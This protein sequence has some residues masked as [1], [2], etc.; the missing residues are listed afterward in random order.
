VDMGNW[1]TS[2][3]YGGRICG[4][5]TPLMPIKNLLDVGDYLS[6]A[7]VSRLQKGSNVLHYCAPVSRGMI[8]RFA[9]PTP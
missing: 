4:A 2:A 3:G 9:Q 5:V 8:L 1:G 7:F 6:E